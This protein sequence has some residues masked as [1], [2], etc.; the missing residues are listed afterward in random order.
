MNETEATN[1]WRW[2]L[3][4]TVAGQ[5]PWNPPTAKEGESNADSELNES[6]IDDAGGDSAE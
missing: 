2:L 3:G 5:K 1:F 4:R 6:G